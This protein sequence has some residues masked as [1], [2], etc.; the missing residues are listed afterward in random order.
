MQW[1]LESPGI[2]GCNKRNWGCSPQT[3]GDS[4]T[5]DKG[6]SYRATTRVLDLGL[7]RIMGNGKRLKPE[8]DPLITKTSSI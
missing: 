2:S 5:G 1:N 8:C 6:N 3:M 7:R 4:R